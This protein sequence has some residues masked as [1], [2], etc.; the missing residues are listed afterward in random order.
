MATVYLLTGGPGTGKTT[1]IRQAIAR[2]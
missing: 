1:V 2:S